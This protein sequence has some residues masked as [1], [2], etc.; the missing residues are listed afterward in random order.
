MVIRKGEA[1]GSMVVPGP[2]MLTVRS[3]AELRSIVLGDQASG[4]PLPVVGLL[5]GD[6]MRTVG[7]TGDAARLRS[8]EPIPHLPIDVIHVTADDGRETICVAHLVARRSW[9]RGPITAVMNAQFIGRW[10]VAPRGHPNDGSFDLVTVAAD[11]G[12]QQRWL[13]RSR[14]LLGTHV[15]HP[16]ITIRRH[17]RAT[18]DLGN[19]RRLWVDGQRWGSAT[20]LELRVEPDALIVCV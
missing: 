13:A 10:D 7:G 20:S 4:Q 18:V 9:W 12:V 5:G 16:L 2:G 3:D 8:A 11:L 15:P 1:W 17:D 14:L 19:R 6:V